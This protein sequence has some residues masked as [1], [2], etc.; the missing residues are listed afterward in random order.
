MKRKVSDLLDT[1]DD[2]VLE[3]NTVTPLSAERIRSLTMNQVKGNKQRNK[4]ILF[5]ILAAA[6]MIAAFSLT[7]FAVGNAAAW[8]RNFFAGRLDRE[9]SDGQAAFIETSAVDYGVGQTVSGYTV[10]VESYL[11]DGSSAFLKL[12][13]RAPEDGTVSKLG[14]DFE[15]IDLLCAD[16]S[17]ACDVYFWTQEA[18]DTEG[19]K[20]VYMLELS[21]VNLQEDGDGNRIMTVKLTDLY[22]GAKWIPGTWQFEID[23]SDSFVELVERPVSGIPARTEENETVDTTVVSARLYPTALRLVFVPSRDRAFDSCQFSAAKAVLKDGSEVSLLPAGW[24]R[25]ADGSETAWWAEFSGGLLS[26]D[27]V[28][29]IVLPG[30]VVLELPKG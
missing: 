13:I 3:L 17:P 11:S 18:L 30:N 12:E 23:I 20:A 5:R 19:K 1:Y 25:E 22:A 7:A 29:S 15:S 26:L 27:E 16:G 9:L 28:V 8:F 2:P 21:S 10:S 6:A 4:R 14:F 24:G